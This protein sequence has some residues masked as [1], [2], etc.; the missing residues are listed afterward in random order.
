MT[1]TLIP[2]QTHTT[3]SNKASTFVKM[4]SRDR[5]LLVPL[6]KKNVSSYTHCVQ[7]HRQQNYLR[8]TKYYYYFELSETATLHIFWNSLFFEK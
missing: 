8:S 1:A 5:I 4:K 2:S 7:L 3:N 6:R